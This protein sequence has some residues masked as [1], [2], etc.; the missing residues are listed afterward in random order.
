[1]KNV[2]GRE[3]EGVAFSKVV[4]SGKVRFSGARPVRELRRYFRDILGARVNSAPAASQLVI[5]LG[6]AGWETRATS[7]RL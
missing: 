2:E 6:L 3:F 1:M 5:G 4:V 7:A